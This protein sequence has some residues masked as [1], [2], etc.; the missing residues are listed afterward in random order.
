MKMTRRQ[1]LGT[2][3]TLAL[4]AGSA[5]KELPPKRDSVIRLT[6]GP[7]VERFRHVQERLLVKHAVVARSKFVHLHKPDL[8][9][10]VQEAGT[11]EPLVLIHGGGGCAAQF[12]PLLG[13]L[14]QSARCYAPDR[15]GCGLTDKIDYV[16]IPFRQHAVS[17]MNGFLDGLGLAKAAIAGNSMGGYW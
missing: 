5:C 9:A 1:F 2:A 6:E 16:G 12:A 14:Q 15:P 11:G 17:C 13:G 4:T 10:H 8:R 3:S 7:E